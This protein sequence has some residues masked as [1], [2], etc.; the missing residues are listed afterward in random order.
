MKKTVNKPAT[1]KSYTGKTIHFNP[2]TKF[3]VKDINIVDIAHSLSQKCRFS[4]HSPLFYSVAQHSCFVSTQCE[5]QYALWGLLHDAS[6]AYLPDVPTPLK[7]MPEMSWFRD[8]EKKIQI[9]ICKR[10]DLPLKEPDEVKIADKRMLYTEKR[11]LMKHEVTGNESYEPYPFIISAVSPLEAK[12]MFLE[13][14]L[15]LTM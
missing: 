8:V 9:L 11:D 6:E 3:K 5:P 15:E 14:F 7:Y 4:A 2:L 13:R 12:V 1:I 10:F